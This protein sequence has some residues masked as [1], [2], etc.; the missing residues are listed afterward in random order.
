MAVEKKQIRTGRE[1]RPVARKD[2]APGRDFLISR[3]SLSVENISRKLNPVPIKAPINFK[4]DSKESLA[5]TREIDLDP[6]S[7]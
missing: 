6:V 1:Q 4:D 5:V 7:T 3:R 2:Q